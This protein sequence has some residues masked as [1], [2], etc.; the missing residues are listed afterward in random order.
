M[1]EFNV[2]FFDTSFYTRCFFITQKMSTHDW[3]NSVMSTT[4]PPKNKVI[5]HIDGDAFFVGVEIAKNPQ[6]K[7]LPVVTGQE[8]GIVTALSY[9]AK[10]LGLVRGMP[11]FQV[12]KKYPKVIIL[13]GDYASYAQYST[14]V[15]DIVRR[16]A[17]G[18]EEY[19]IDEC[20]ADVT[21]LDRTLKM[22]Y[23]DIA[24]NIKNEITTELDL[25]V[26]V[27]LAPTK[28]LAKVA[29]NWKKPNGLT[30]IEQSTVPEFLAKVPNGKVWGIG[31]STEEF[32]KGMGVDT[33]LDF[34]HKDVSWVKKNL[35]KPYEIIWQELNG[36]SRMDVDTEVKNIY[37]SIQKTKTFYPPTHDKIFLWSQLSKHFEDACR[38]ARHYDLVPKKISVILKTQDFK[39][40]TLFVVVP[41]PSNSP[42]VLLELARTLFE[43]IYDKN[44]LYRTAGV[45]LQDLV[46]YFLLQKDLFGEVN[47]GD[48]FDAIHKQIDSLEEKMGKR[49]VYLGS[50]SKALKNKAG[51]TDADE[52]DRDLLFL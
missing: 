36:V 49:L 16:Y 51:G 11:I 25:S 2:I 12:K 39:T 1:K 46:P 44:K 15:F 47:R 17:Y 33:A 38:K 20:F 7:G 45:V 22:S 4:L 5:F 30:L 10:A 29:S 37:S 32:L 28:V 42:E 23:W 50:T 43:K 21:G 6:L 9:E 52:L 24:Q 26:S 41:L 34:I 3:Y 35:S 13:S 18:V 27:G 48:K 14:M 8:R 40:S 31:P 19:S